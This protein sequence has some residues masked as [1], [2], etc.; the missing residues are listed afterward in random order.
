MLGSIASSNATNA[1]LLNGILNTL[2]GIASQGS[3]VDAA[4]NSSSGSGDSSSDSSL[5]SDVT[6]IRGISSPS[7]ASFSCPSPEFLSILGRNY[8]F[9]YDLLCNFA[10]SMRGL[11]IAIGA[12]SALLIVITA[13]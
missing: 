4:G 13:L 10:D 3:P 7:S 12:F 6:D 2:Q 5:S 8:E 11:V 9:S 1:N